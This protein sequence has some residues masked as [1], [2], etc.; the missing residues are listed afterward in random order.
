MSLR[1]Y[2]VLCNES[3][4]FVA[5]IPVPTERSTILKENFN[6]WYTIKSYYIS[7]MLI[8]LPLSTFCCFLFSIIIYVMTGWPMEIMRFSVFFVISLLIVLIASTCGLIIGTSFNVIVS[9]T[10]KPKALLRKGRNNFMV[11]FY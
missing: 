7:L 4:R 11:M 8:D 6:R 2:D 9:K 1:K 3:L 10:L 5:L